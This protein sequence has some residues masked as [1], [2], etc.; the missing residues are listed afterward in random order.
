M[1]RVARSVKASRARE[2]HHSI[3]VIE[4]L[5]RKTLLSS[6]LFALCNQRRCAAF[7]NDAAERHVHLAAT[8]YHSGGSDR[9]RLVRDAGRSVRGAVVSTV[10]VAAHRLANA[11]RIASARAAVVGRANQIGRNHARLASI[12]HVRQSTAAPK[13]NR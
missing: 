1:I 9:C 5:Q 11:D 12:E 6:A 4:R 2:P 10:S 13:T 8:T 3:G 7:Y